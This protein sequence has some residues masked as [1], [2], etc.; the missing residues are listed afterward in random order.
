M[1]AFETFAEMLDYWAPDRLGLA[2]RPVATGP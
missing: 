2:A 1:P